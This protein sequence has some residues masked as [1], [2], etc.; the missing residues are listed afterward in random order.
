MTSTITLYI[1]SDEG[2]PSAPVTTP[3]QGAISFLG[4]L[5]ASGAGV[6][7]ASCVEPGQRG[8][9]VVFRAEPVDGKPIDGA[10]AANF[11]LREIARLPA[12]PA[13]ED[14]AGSLA[15][16]SDGLIAVGAFSTSVSELRLAGVVVIYRILDADRVPVYADAA[17]APRHVELL[18]QLR[19]PDATVSLIFGS[20]LAAQDGLLAVGA[21]GI[22][23][24]QGGVYLYR[25]TP[26]NST[27]PVT[28]HTVVWPGP[29]AP[30]DSSGVLVGFIRTQDE[31]NAVAT[32]LLAVNRL[33]YV[34]FRRAC[35]DLTQVADA[36]PQMPGVLQRMGTGLA[37]ND[38]G[39]AAA[40]GM[41]FGSALAFVGHGAG[42]AVGAPAYGTNSSG[43]IALYHLPPDFDTLDT[44]ALPAGGSLPGVVR[45]AVDVGPSA[46][47]LGTTLASSDGNLLSAAAPEA[48]GGRGAVFVYNTSAYCAG[49]GGNESHVQLQRGAVL[50]APSNAGLSPSFGVALAMDG[51]DIA[52]GAPGAANGR[53]LCYLYHVAEMAAVPTRLNVTL[54]SNLRGIGDNGFGS[55]LALSSEY[56]AIGNVDRSAVRRDRKHSVYIIRRT[57]R[58]LDAS[59]VVMVQ[60]AFADN[61]FGWSLSLDARR[62]II[63]APWELPTLYRRDGSKI[64][65]GGGGAV[66]VFALPPVDAV[67]FEVTLFGITY[68]LVNGT[69][70]G[71][72]VAIANN[73]ILAGAP[74]VTSIDFYEGGGMARAFM[75]SEEPP[76]MRVSSQLYADQSSPFAR[77]G[78]AVA[79]SADGR[80]G[81]LGGPGHMGKGAVFLV[82]REDANE[83][84]YVPVIATR[85]ELQWP[86][87]P[88]V[89]IPSEATTT[90]ADG[91]CALH[92]SRGDWDCRW[93][94]WRCRVRRDNCGGGRHRAAEAQRQCCS[95]QRL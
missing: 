81:A 59:T 56:L 12:P 75:S 14:F 46:S 72:A 18:V 65:V 54:L 9:V 68:D 35:P 62:L 93:H 5:M 52:V 8:L 84:L 15:V 48:D 39:D 50:H 36:A 55:S 67:A 80:R 63:S 51:M 3:V 28:L 22:G 16:T 26:S 70:L 95:H 69:L 74:G 57:A 25:T 88:V 64:P 94:S 19:A 43:L 78:A 45:L 79:L 21:I 86:T 2:V 82:R 60:S 32:R 77:V 85:E 23:S 49:V 6:V 90:V 31:N 24:S 17:G 76:I 73:T 89:E 66:R 40:A 61:G 47:H 27:Q 71:S 29:S 41:L 58:G 91:S 34:T 10:A 7:A 1:L 92:L 83:S 33:D 20:S 53:G 13:A 38:D 87:P 4:F 30:F 44:L 37:F 42:L 11:K